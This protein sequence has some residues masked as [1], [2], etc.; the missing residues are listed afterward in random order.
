MRFQGLLLIALIASSGCSGKTDPISQ[1][2][3]QPIS[4][5]PKVVRH[6]FEYHVT[7]NLFLKQEIPVEL[8]AVVANSGGSGDVRIRVE[9][10]Q[11]SW[12][13]RVHFA[14]G[15]QRTVRVA[16]PN[17]D[18][19]FCVIKAQA[20]PPP[21]LLLPTASPPPGKNFAAKVIQSALIGG[22]IGGFFSL[23]VALLKRLGRHTSTKA[24][25][26]T[27]FEA[28]SR[29]EVVCSICGT[30][31]HGADTST[32]LCAYCKKRAAGR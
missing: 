2:Q 11:K 8:E 22:I 17:A 14:A 4:P 27:P 29:R 24:H 28:E 3:F 7:A 1:G 21:R 18:P 32:G 9:Q 12:E 15:E 23:L 19:G 13:E 31:L 20:D 25:S 30:L 26:L 6:K 5:N 10:G 16:L